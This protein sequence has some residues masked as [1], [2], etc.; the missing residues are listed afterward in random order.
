MYRE[1]AR[2]L[3][4]KLKVLEKIETMAA[5]FETSSY[6]DFEYIPS[7]RPLLSLSI[8]KKFLT[9]KIILIYF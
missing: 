5:D 4:S 8:K 9:L 2:I 6:P 7:Q 1:S 3:D